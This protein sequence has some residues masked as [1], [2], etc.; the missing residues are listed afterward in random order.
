VQRR[1]LDDHAPDLYRFQ[2]GKGIHRPRTADVYLDRQQSRFGDVGSE[3][4]CDRPTWL[5]PADD[6][7]LLLK[8]QRIDFHHA[9]VDREVQITSDF[10][11]EIVRPLLHFGESLRAFA[12][13]RNRDTPLDQSIEEL[14]LCLERKVF[15]VGSRD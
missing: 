11:L 8:C 12:V 2:N 15:P 4:A 10:V 5:A 13:G 1:Q 3:L 14:G 9:T 7:Q 6:A